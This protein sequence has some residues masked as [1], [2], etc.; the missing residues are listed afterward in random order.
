MAGVWDV[1]VGS[2]SGVMADNWDIIMR[3][4]GIKW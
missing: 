2:L 3:Y 4:T 1:S